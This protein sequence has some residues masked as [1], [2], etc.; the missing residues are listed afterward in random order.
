[1]TRGHPGGG[2]VRIINNATIAPRSDLRV[3]S[4][5]SV[6]RL[7]RDLEVGEG[8]CVHGWLTDGLYLLDGLDGGA[9]VFTDGC[10]CGS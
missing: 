4:L 6:R 7:N 3:P 9:G 5:F 8:R 1:M 2:D 10:A